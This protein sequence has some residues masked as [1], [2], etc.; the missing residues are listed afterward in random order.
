M[1]KDQADKLREII[2]KVGLQIVAEKMSGLSIIDVQIMSMKEI[3]ALL[4]AVNKSQDETEKI[5][6]KK[7][8]LLDKNKRFDEALNAALYGGELPKMKDAEII[9]DNVTTRGVQRVDGPTKTKLLRE[10]TEGA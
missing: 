1:E 4:T 2:E 6:I 3:I 10:S 8:E 9:K 5:K 7:V